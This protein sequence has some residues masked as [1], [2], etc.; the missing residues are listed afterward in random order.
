MKHLVIFVGD[1]IEKILSGKKTLE[2]RFSKSKNLPYCSVFKNDLLLLKQSSSDIF[3][4]VVVDNVLYYENLNPKS[5]KILKEKYQSQLKMSEKF[6][7]EK[8]KS[9]FC[10]LIFLK[11]PE[12][13]LSPVQYKKRDRRSWIILE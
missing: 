4:S 1:A 8:I 5:I 2:I 13:F 9:K 10:T 11:K 6:W 3:G 7:Q 12:R